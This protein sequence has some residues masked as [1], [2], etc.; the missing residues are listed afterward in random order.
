LA[1]YKL[2]RKTPPALETGG[3]VTKSGIAEVH[4]GEAVSG[5]KNQMGFGA[6]MS[7]TEGYLS[8]MVNQLNTMNQKINDLSM[9]S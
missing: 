7:K 4:K 1:G 9:Q 3:I 8:T 5:T 6:D 2:L